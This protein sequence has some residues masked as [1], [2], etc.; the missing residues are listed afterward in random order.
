MTATKR[1]RKKKKGTT[2]ERIEVGRCTAAAVAVQGAT[3]TK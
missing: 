1:K 3:V 2:K